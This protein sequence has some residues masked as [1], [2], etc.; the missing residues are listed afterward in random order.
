MRNPGPRL[1]WLLPL[2]AF[3][4]GSNRLLVGDNAGAGGKVG[5]SAIG[6]AGAA[7]GQTGVAGAPLD[8][9]V[10]TGAGG[11]G[12]IAPPD[13]GAGA[14]PDGALCAPQCAGK[15]GG[16]DSCNGTCP[17]TCVA[18]L[19]CGGA[20][21]PNTCGNGLHAI[22]GTVVGLSSTIVLA[23]GNDRL[24]VSSN[25]TFVFP[26]K[27]SSYSVSIYTQP[28]APAQQCNGGASGI[29]STDVTDI[30][31][32]CPPFIVANGLNDPY[33]LKVG[34]SN[35]YFMQ[36]DTS[37]CSNVNRPT[38]GVSMVPTKGGQPVL[39]AP[40]GNDGTYCESWGPAL[41]SSYVY[42]YD[43][44]DASFHRATLGGTNATT[45][46]NPRIQL[47]DFILDAANDV[48]YYHY[49]DSDLQT[50]G[51]ARASVD[52][53]GKA[54][55]VAGVQAISGFAIDASN[56]Y[57]TDPAGE[58]VNKAA[59]NASPLPTT[60]TIIEPAS[61]GGAWYPFV[62]STTLYWV[63]LGSTPREAPLASPTPADLT[64]LPAGVG[65]YGIIADANF[66]WVLADA[67]GLG[68][69]RIYKVPVAGGSPVLVAK[70]LY[71][72]KSF[73][74]DATHVYWATL[75]M[76]NLSDGTISMIVK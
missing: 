73:T 37:D 36:S 31:I 72:A 66:V 4:C 33:G 74:M 46:F 41:D 27:A 75:S 14:G 62:S 65:S 43:F 38:T 10:P 59:L 50:N 52:G 51:I 2:V 13:G 55:F 49:F 17:D 60:P 63:T 22:G 64:T 29:A 24:T 40:S 21:T 9:A 32:D 44:S 56:L 35:L 54:I 42:W 67:N 47:H 48:F 6:A 1:I 76:A 70:G 11:G 53:S 3:A 15:C 5:D 16:P 8:G 28:G 25:G 23:N 45:L 20:G 19:T 26:Q 58:M 71:Q 18:P 39:I 69:G 7:G 34:G 12:S 68:N 61:G 30:V 57:W